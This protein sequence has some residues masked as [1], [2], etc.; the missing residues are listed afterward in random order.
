MR[1]FICLSLLALSVLAHAGDE[2]AL[3]GVIGNRAAVLSVGGGDPKTVKLG[4]T[5]SG[6]TV[7][8]VDR[9]SATIEVN[10]EKAAA[11]V[12]ERVSERVP[13]RGGDYQWR[14]ARIRRCSRIWT[15]SVR[16]G[17]GTE[18]IGAGLDDE[19]R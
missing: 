18:S 3:I 13:A 10:G 14:P 17:A 19:V 16:V 6:I 15:R 11:I 5:W 1:H 9:E 7:H 2:V 8:A 12:V 4:Q